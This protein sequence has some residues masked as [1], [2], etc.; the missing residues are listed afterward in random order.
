MCAILLCDLDNNIVFIKLVIIDLWYTF[1]TMYSF[2]VLFNVQIYRNLQIIA[3][4]SY[5]V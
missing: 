4:F 1:F 2:Y 5:L 3:V